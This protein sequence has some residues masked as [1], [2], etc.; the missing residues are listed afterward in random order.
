MSIRHLSAQESKAG[1]LRQVHGSPVYTVH[2]ETLPQRRKELNGKSRG[3]VW[4][5]DESLRGSEMTWCTPVSSCLPISTLLRFLI[6][7]GLE[8]LGSDLHSLAPEGLSSLYL[9]GFN[10]YCSSCYCA[11]HITNSLI[12][13][14]S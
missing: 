10:V 8:H 2:N 9:I 13:A 6:C 3:V 5:S 4:G 11:F 1:G 12:R 14:I 7:L